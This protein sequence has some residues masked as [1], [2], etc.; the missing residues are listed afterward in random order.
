MKKIRNNWFCI[1][2]KPR[3]ELIA[4]NELT[5]KG[6]EIYFPR[7]KRIIRHARKSENKIFSLF[8]RYLFAHENNHFSYSL[9]NRTRGV[10][11][12]VHYN[13][14][15]PMRVK[16]EIIDFIKSRE[17]SKGYIKLNE[18]RFTKGDKVIFTKGIF[19]NLRAVFQ[20]QNDSGRANILLKFLG[21]EHILPA[22]LDYLDRQY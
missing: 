13:D 7:Y 4:Y 19:A 2:T 20:K 22:P 18:H 16:Q 12:Y 3:E 6:I 21:R 9:I 14:G 15:S 1:Y 17:D 10:S 11:N 8:P 5:I